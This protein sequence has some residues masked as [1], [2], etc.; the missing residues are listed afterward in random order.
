MCTR[1][2][3]VFTLA[4]H[5]KKYPMIVPVGRSNVGVLHAA[6]ELHFPFVGYDVSYKVHI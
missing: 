4:L 1:S 3:A 5:W 2:P 6:D